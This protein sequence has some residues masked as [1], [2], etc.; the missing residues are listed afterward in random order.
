MA[1]DRLDVYL[2]AETLAWLESESQA[3]GK[4]KAEII[5]EALRDRRLAQSTIADLIREATIALA[6][7]IE[8]DERYDPVDDPREAEALSALARLLGSAYAAQGIA[9]ALNAL[10]VQRTLPEPAGLL[11]NETALNWLDELVDRA[12]RPHTRETMVEKLVGEAWRKRAEVEDG[13]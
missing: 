11:L 3:A 13:D 12:R 6:R 7:S 2:G 4:G 1:R 8:P 9:D 10:W 5:K